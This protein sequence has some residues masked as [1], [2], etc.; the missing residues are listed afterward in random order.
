MSCSILY[1][2]VIACFKFS[3]AAW[4]LSGF[5]KAVWANRMY[6]V[7]NLYLVTTFSCLKNGLKHATINF[8]CTR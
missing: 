1:F 7:S 8:Q 4:F 2:L 3:I 6:N 5:L